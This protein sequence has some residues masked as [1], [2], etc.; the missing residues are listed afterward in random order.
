MLYQENGEPLWSL[1]INAVMNDGTVLGEDG[2]EIS[3]EE[4]HEPSLTALARVA[5]DPELVHRGSIL[6]YLL[7]TLLALLNVFQICF[8]GFFFRL[9]L[10]GHVRNIDDAEPSDW[11]IAMERIGWLVLAGMCLFLYWQA[12]TVTV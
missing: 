3:P 5:L 12:L 8:P 10:L 11:Y 6:L 1:Q 9:S 4:Q 2:R 7:I